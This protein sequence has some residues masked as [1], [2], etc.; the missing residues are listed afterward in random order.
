[1]RKRLQKMQSLLFGTLMQMDIMLLE[2][3]EPVN[4]IHACTGE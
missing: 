1:M 3:E 2:A 4:C